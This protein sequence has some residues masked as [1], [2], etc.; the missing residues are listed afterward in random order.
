MDS[1]PLTPLAQAQ[2]AALAAILAPERA[3]EQPPLSDPSPL[4]VTA[5]IGSLALG[6]AERIVLDWAAGC[7]HRYRVRL[8]VLRDAPA[9]WPVPPGV[10]IVRLAGAALPHALERE[11]AQI[12]TGGNPVVLCHLLTVAERRALERGGARAVP[13]LH[14]ALAGWIEPA[15]ALA[16]APLAIAVSRDAAMGLRRSGVRTPCAVIRHIPPM[17]AEPPDARRAGRERLESGRERWEWREKWDLP[18]GATV[19]GMIG[20][21]K[22]QKSYPRALR[23]LER[24]LA[25]RDAYLVIVGGPVGRDGSV[26]WHA[27][28]AQARRLGIEQRVRLPGFVRDAADCLPAFDLLLNTSRYEGLSVATLEALAAGLPVVASAV[29]G[30]GELPA[31]GLTLVPYEAAVVEWVRAADAA[32]GRRPE[33]PA[34]RGAAT[35]R[36]WTLFHLL[37]PY[38]PDG[39]C[40]F[41]TANLNAGGAQRSLVN[42]ALG[43]GASFRFEIAVCGDSSS[44]WFSR[45]LARAGVRVHRSAASRDCYDHAEAILRRAIAGRFG[46]VCFWNVD[47]KVKLLLAKALDAVPVKLVDVSPGG[48]GFREMEETRGFQQWIA[49]SEDE[50]YARLDCLVMKYRGSG[51]AQLNGKVEIIPNGVPEP[52]GDKAPDPFSQHIVMSGRI[53]PSK[54]LVEAVTAMRLLWQRHPRAE[55]HVL[56]GAERRHADYAREL[57]DAIGSELDERVFLHGVAFDAPGRIA[58]AAAALVLGEHQGCPN[59]VLEALAAGVPVVANDSGGTRELVVAGR[60]GLLLSGRDPREIAAALG[61]ILD[62]PALARKLSKKGRQHVRARFSM[63]RM[64]A[65]YRRL[66][67]SHR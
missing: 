43:L 64:I 29:G 8:I 59:A 22:P 10:E 4:E 67:D 39:G 35:H 42:L 58:R 51:P 7:G 46:T 49:W 20:A 6:G 50:Y 14:N 15:D 11:G 34:W 45:E 3:P 25:R 55:L 47:A 44:D 38:E 16:D 24:L 19:I 60:T 63:A 13:V 9:E 48:Y 2:Q 17:I 23:I 66:L 28:L 36:L 5:A 61:R 12:A 65:A 40:L 56:G 26:A 30:Q 32:L 27:V 1:T 37:R 54:F 52:Q 21:V 18:G 31:P 53:A 62:D 33:R 57:L 41:V